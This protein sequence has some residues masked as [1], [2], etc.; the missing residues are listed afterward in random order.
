M[1][2][3]LISQ[4]HQFCTWVRDNLGKTANFKI[5]FFEFASSKQSD[6][7]YWIWIEDIYHQ[8]TKSLES[9]VQSIPAMKALCE[10]RLLLQGGN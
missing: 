2:P 3:I 6:L 8:S 7:E 4:M 9:L 5:S 10:A 1:N